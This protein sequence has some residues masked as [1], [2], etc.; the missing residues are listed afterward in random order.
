VN[1]LSPRPHDETARAGPSAQ[2]LGDGEGLPV[3]FV[4]ALSHALLSLSYLLVLTAF[5]DRLRGVLTRRRVRRGFDAVTGTALLGF[6]ARL[7][8]ER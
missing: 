3:L 2:F 4:F 8:A 6:S 5:L 7:A 1:V